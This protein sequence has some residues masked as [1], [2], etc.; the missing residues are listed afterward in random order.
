[1]NALAQPA[2]APRALRRWRLRRNLSLSPRQYFTAYAVAAAVLAA[3]G[4]WFLVLG[5]WPVAAFYGVQVLGLGIAFWHSARHA[6]DGEEVVLYD[7]G[8]LEVCAT[9]GAQERR[10][11]FPAAWCRFERSPAGRGTAPPGL[12]IA[13]GRQRI[14]VGRH[15]SR[16]Q[17][18]RLHQELRAAVRRLAAFGAVDE[19]GALPGDGHR[20]QGDRA[21]VLR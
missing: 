18:E 19:G 8:E 1:M 9:C 10:H 4:L 12:W 2:G 7:T 5:F 15:A 16:L 14:A 20:W 17:R 21:S 3:L 11:R 6:L 13:C